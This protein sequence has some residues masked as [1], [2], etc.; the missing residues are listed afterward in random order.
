MHLVHMDTRL[1]PHVLRQGL[2]LDQAVGSPRI[3]IWIL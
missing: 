1:A 3:Q 2:L